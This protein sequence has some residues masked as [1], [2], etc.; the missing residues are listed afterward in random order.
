MISGNTS[1]GKGIDHAAVLAHNVLLEDIV[2]ETLPLV[3][4]VDLVP[5]LAFLSSS[6]AFA[7]FLSALQDLVA[8][9]SFFSEARNSVKSTVRSAKTGGDRLLA[10]EG[11]VCCPF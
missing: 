8:Y 1:P 9:R 5:H 11:N 7:S 2:D 10:L 3:H 4:Y 6:T